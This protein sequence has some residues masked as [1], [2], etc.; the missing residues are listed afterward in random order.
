VSGKQLKRIALA[1]VAGALV[2]MVVIAVLQM[3]RHINGMSDA[4]GLRLFRETLEIVKGSY[5]EEVDTKKLVAGAIKGMLASLDPH[6]SFLEP[7]PFKEMGIATSGSFGGLG[8]EI[9]IKDGRL[10]VISPIEDTPAYRAGIRSN[11]YIWKIGDKPTRGLTI[12]ESVRLMRGEPGTRV[13]LSILREGDSKVHRYEITRAIIKVTSVKSKLLE[14]GFGYLRISQFQERTGGDM[15]RALDRLR[16]ASGGS[17][18]GLVLDL[19]N[20]PGGLLDQ[21]VAV[22]G[23]FIGDRPDNALVV[24]T[25]GRPGSARHD[26]NASIGEKEPRYPMVV[27][28]NG[29]SASASEIVAGALQ[30]HKRAVIMGTQTFGKGSVQ[31]VVPLRGNNGLSLTIARYYT[32][33]GRSIQARGI[34]PDIIVG[35]RDMKPILSNYSGKRQRM[36]ME[37]DLENHLDA[38]DGPEKAPAA[39][40]PGAA[41]PHPAAPAVP[42]PSGVADPKND[43]QLY[44]ALELLKGLNVVERFQRQAP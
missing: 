15:V 27:L 21:S 14:P 2:A 39:A 40:P 6:S 33:S 30:D 19:R 5:V 42:P 43:F 36:L 37:K 26:L 29:G 16:S 35:Q 3:R 11:D 41:P 22:A 17:L 32:P 31:S 8:I 4:E 7:E 12:N 25:Q 18:K 13:T 34:L 10:T 20:N 24:Y 23:R 28:V 38:G 9:N 44:R 1:G